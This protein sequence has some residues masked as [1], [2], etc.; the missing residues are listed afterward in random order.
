[1]LRGR[2]GQSMAVDDILEVVD[3]DDTFQ[4][5]DEREKNAEQ[6][7]VLVAVLAKRTASLISF[8]TIHTA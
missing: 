8:M 7:R 6:S 5:E 3:E 4:N 1:M 2:V